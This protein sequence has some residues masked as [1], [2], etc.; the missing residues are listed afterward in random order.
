MT[1]TPLERRLKATI[2][3]TGP[4]SV[5]DWMALC[6]SDPE[7]GYYMAREPFGAEGDFI[8]A[9][10]VSQMFGELIGAWLIDAHERIGAPA[11]FD[12]VELGPGRGTLMADIWRTLRLRPALQHAARLTLVE[13]SPRLRARQKDALA[14]VGAVPRFADRFDAIPRG[15]PLLLVANEFF[16]ALPIRQWI[17]HQGVW[18]ER[19]VG[20]DADGALTFGLGAAVLPNTD[21]P[22]AVANASDGAV[23]E[24]AAPANAIAETIARRIVEDGGAALFIDYGYTQTAIGDTL[25]AVRA[26]EHRAPLDRPGETDLTAHVNFEALARAATAAGAHV[27]GPVTQGTFLLRLG[28]LDRAGRLGAGKDPATQEKLAHDVER[29]A[30]PEEMGTLFKVMAVSRDGLEMAGF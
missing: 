27:H 3:L 25:Q 15:R 5:A 2:Q 11:A 17:R 29:L 9:P 6:L 16:D 13:T 22:T 8:T 24:T 23:L 20:L 26:H 30:G 14:A 10:D 18:R 12:L 1:S 4:M 28:L 19:V 7:H 21:L